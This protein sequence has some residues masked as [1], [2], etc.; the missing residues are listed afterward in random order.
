MYNA[1]GGVIMHSSSGDPAAVFVG[2]GSAALLGMSAVA[3]SDMQ[4][5]GGG[6]NVLG[7]LGVKAAFGEYKQR[8]CQST[9]FHHVWSCKHDHVCVRLSKVLSVVACYRS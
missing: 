6:A 5:T 3:M 4:G 8:A 7:E 1:A 2:L 9:L